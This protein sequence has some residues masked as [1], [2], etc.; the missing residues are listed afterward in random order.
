MGGLGGISA[1][2]RA[3]LF[4]FFRGPRKTVNEFPLGLQTVCVGADVLPCEDGGDIEGL[5]EFALAG[6]HAAEGNVVLARAEGAGG[7]IG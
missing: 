3:A 5:G 1:L 7:I 2:S 4:Q 6:G